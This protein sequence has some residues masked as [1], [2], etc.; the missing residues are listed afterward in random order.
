MKYAL[1]A[2]AFLLPCGV[3][4][5]DTT[6]FAEGSVWV[7]QSPIVEGETVL[8]HAALTNGSTA[9][10]TGTLVFKD[11]TFAIGSV[12]FTLASG[13][14]RIISLSWKATKGSHSITASIESPSNTDA[15]GS[16]SVDVSVEAKA[17]PADTKS[18]TLATSSAAAVAF[19]DSDA[20]QQAIGSVSPKA[21]E[22]AT[23]VFSTIDSVRKSG[24]E[25]LAKQAAAAEVKVKELSA[26]KTALEKKD[27][28]E[29]KSESRTTTIYQI[30]TTILLYIYS[31]LLVVVSKAGFF[32][33]LFFLIFFFLLYK[34]YQRFRR[35]NYNY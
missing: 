13:E 14:A 35:P 30:L 8:I 18:K 10:L 9:K 3:I 20:I 27:T 7:S 16:Q 11:N 26:K 15:A 25:L 5:A 21:E 28:P 22:V 24:A 1:L 4:F 34:L 17:A 6:G 2:I 32:Y 23:P 29:A 12:P 31:V 19:S 33:P